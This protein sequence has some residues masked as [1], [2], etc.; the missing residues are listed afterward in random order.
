MFTG[1]GTESDNAA[2]A[3][4]VAPAGGRAVCPAAE[5]HAVLHVV[6]RHGGTVVAV[7]A[8]GRVDLDA[9]ADGARPTTSPSSA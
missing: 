5:H 1:C 3:G 9:L 4:A 8:A 6:E 2:I 7:D